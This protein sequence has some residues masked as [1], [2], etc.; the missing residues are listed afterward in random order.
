[1]FRFLFRNEQLPSDITVSFNPIKIPKKFP[2]SIKRLYES[3][4]FSLLHIVHTGTGLTDKELIYWEKTKY[5]DQAIIFLFLTYGLRLKEVA[6]LEV[7]SFNFRRKEFV[8]FR[9]RDKESIM[10]INQTVEEAIK[11]YLRFERDP[12]SK[13]RSLFLSLRGTRLCD[14]AIRNMIKKY[15][16]IALGTTR[17]QGFSPH[18]LRATAASTL[19][20]RGFSIFDVQNLMDHD[21][22]VTTQL[23]ASHRKHVREDIVRNF[24][25]SESDYS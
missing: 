11:K 4:M 15:T 21:N 19:I 14:R 5:R 16:S 10:P 13:E 7:G 24:E 1:M 22:I 8:I 12:K 20:E 17:G 25:L 9:K 3:E 6:E 23:Y 18:K 2:D